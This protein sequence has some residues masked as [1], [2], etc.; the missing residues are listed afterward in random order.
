[1]NDLI[2]SVRRYRAIEP[3]IG[4]AIAACFL[5]L[6]MRVEHMG[7]MTLATMFHM[8]LANGLEGAEQRAS[9][10]QEL[11]EQSIEYVGIAARRSSRFMAAN[12]Q[13]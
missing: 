8:F 4:L 12:G 13:R 7:A 3:N 6:G 5:D 2:E 11:P 10:L 1:M 9:V